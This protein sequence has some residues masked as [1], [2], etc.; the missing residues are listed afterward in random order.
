[1]CEQ[2][3]T[4]KLTVAPEDGSSLADSKVED[5]AIV[6]AIEGLFPISASDGGGNEVPIKLL[7]WDLE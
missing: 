3:I 6:D 2:S 1:M 4:I 5:V 7:D